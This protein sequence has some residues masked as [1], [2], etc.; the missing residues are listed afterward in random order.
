MASEDSFR[1]DNGDDSDGSFEEADNDEYENRLPLMLLKVHRSRQDDA[2]IVSKCVQYPLYSRAVSIFRGPNVNAGDDSS[3]DDMPLD[4]VLFN[5]A[6]RRRAYSEHVRFCMLHLAKRSC[7][8]GIF[9]A[10]GGVFLCSPHGAT[11]DNHPF[12]LVHVLT[13]TLVTGA[14]PKIPIDH[15]FCYRLMPDGA[16]WNIDDKTSGDRFTK[17]NEWLE[18]PW[19]EEKNEILRIPSANLQVAVRMQLSGEKIYTICDG[20]KDLVQAWGRF[21]GREKRLFGRHGFR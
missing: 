17:L 10:E 7:T 20:S 18:V 8:A 15:A 21:Y 16:G 4:Q 2:S 19:R 12:Y 6:E 1:L 3:D 9:L 11:R 13:W 14:Y 5:E